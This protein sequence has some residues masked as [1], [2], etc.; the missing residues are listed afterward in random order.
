MSENSNLHLH[1]HTAIVTGSTRGIGATIAKNLAIAGASVVVSG[2]TV[3]AGNDVVQ[4]IINEGGEATFVQTDVRNPEDI[5]HLIRQA[6]SQYDGIDVLVNNAAFE[7]DTRPN[8][9]NINTWNSIIQTNFRA[10]WL[11]AKHAYP[12]LTESVQASIIN[13]S[14]NH[15]IATQPRKFPYNAVKAGIDGMTRSMAVSWGIDGIRVN[16]VNPGWTM[17]ERIAEQLT[18]E[19][20]A[21]L[22]RIHPVGRIGTPKDVANAVLF[23]AGDMSSFI[24]GECIVVDGGR[25]AVLQDDLYLQD[26]HLDQHI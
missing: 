1:E 8:E 3:E 17:V 18:N 12:S 6:E 22:D 4:E 15:A 9:V 25:T 23:L 24:T 14:S 19:E 26:H 20:L 7:T 5:E 21:Y 2:R 16:S 10:Y 11:T 13:I